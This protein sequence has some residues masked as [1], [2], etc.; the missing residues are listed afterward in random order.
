MVNLDSHSSL[1]VP[2]LAT[3]FFMPPLPSAYVSRQRLMDVLDQGLQ[4]PLIL[5]SA[6]PGFGKSMLLCNWIHSRPGLKTGWLC[7]EPSDQDWGMFF[8]Y[9]VA[10]W[11]HIFP[12]AGEMA[13]AELNASTSLDK[14]TLTNLLLNDLVSV[15]KGEGN[16]QVVL[17]LDDYHNIASIAIQETVAYLVEHLLPNCH[18]VLLTRADPPLPLARWR[19]RGWMLEVRADDLRFTLNEAAD[20]LNQSMHLNLSSDQIQSLEDRTEGWVVGLQLAALSLQ[21]RDRPQEFIS[22]FSGTQRFVIDYLVEEVLQRQPEEIRQFMQTTALLDRFCGSLCDAV[23]DRPAFSSQSLLEGLEKANLF[24]V[25]LDDHRNWYRYHGLFADLLRARLQQTT[26]ERISEVYNRAANWCS[27]NNLWR[28]AIEYALKAKDLELGAALFEQ[29][30]HFGGREFL[31]SGIHPLIEPFPPNFI[32]VHPILSL[33]KAIEMIE[34]AQ[35][36][37][38]E[39]LLRFAEDEIQKRPHFEGQDEILGWIYVIQSRAASILGDSTWST[40]ASRHI[41]HLIPNDGPAN[42]HALLHAGLTYYYSGDLHRTDTY[43]QKALDLSQANDYTYGRLCLSDNLARICCYKGELHRAEELFQRA[44]QLSGKMQDRY[45]RWHGALQRDYSELL[46]EQNRLEEA[47]AQMDSGLALCQKWEMASGLGLG[48][49]NM[50]RILLAFG[51]PQGATSM[52]IKAEELRRNHTVYPDLDTLVQLFHVQLCLA[53]GDLEQAKQIQE[54]CLQ[55][56]CCLHD[57]NCEWTQIVQARVLL[58]TDRPTEALALLAGRLEKAKAFGRGR[59]WLEMVLLT[60]MALHSTAKPD[61]ALQMLREGLAYSKVQ[62]FRRIFVD[63]GNPMQELLERFRIQDPQSSLS[64]FILDL[65]S[66]FP[67][68][69]VFHSKNIK[70]TNLGLVEPLSNRELEILQL[71]CQ[72]LSNREIARQLFLSSGTVKAYIHNIYGKL[73]VRDRPQAIVK[74]NL[75]GLVK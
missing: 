57:L 21:G 30:V 33:A 63:E 23:M 17:V 70:E 7:I 50:G 44:I 64:E 20:Y 13:L 61:H 37:G 60:A 38:V 15:C 3:R 16:H 25:S 5:I 14:Q 67:A 26:P 47:R 42:T 34:N 1:S 35:L 18:L 56:S 6:P 10:A 39:P 73:G 2:L 40:Q 8:R 41:A 52:L 58:K 59:N 72:G 22:Q 54:A 45:P 71:V 74:A 55:S 27:Q 11:Q 19:S 66:M 29:A 28:E 49:V 68:G 9:L 51:D 32:K 75:I 31:Y 43:W 24:L 65:L 69:Q 4:R 53:S 12:T 46:R 48:Y 62:G 36:I